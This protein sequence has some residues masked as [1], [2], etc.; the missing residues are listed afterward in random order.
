MQN[1]NYIRERPNY[2][3]H[4][5]YTNLL[6]MLFDFRF[7]GDY[8]PSFVYSQLGRDGVAEWVSLTRTF[9]VIGD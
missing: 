2:T 9:R 1:A 8:P 6:A 4:P 5:A 3:P 7:S